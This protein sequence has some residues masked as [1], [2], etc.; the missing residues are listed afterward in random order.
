M[1]STLPQQPL[2]QP[3]QPPPQSQ[4]QQQQQQQPV[5]VYPNTASRDPHQSDSH[6]SGSFGTVFIVLA[7]IIVVSGIAC[8]LGRLCNKQQL[9]KDRKDNHHPKSSKKSKNQHNSKVGQGDDIEFGLPPPMFGRPMTGERE[10]PSGPHQKQPGEANNGPYNPYAPSPSQQHNNHQK[11]EHEDHG[12]G[13]GMNMM[14]MMNGGEQKRGFSNGGKYDPR[15]KGDA[16]LNYTVKEFQE[17]E[18]PRPII[19]IRDRHAR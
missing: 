14:K 5:L 8:C 6:S 15:F 4:P 13:G 11:D 19:K 7:V 1:A 3:L 16:K 10:G 9:K 2:P 18:L 17:E 12:G